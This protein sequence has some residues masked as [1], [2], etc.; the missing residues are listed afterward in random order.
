MLQTETSYYLRH[1]TTHT[2]NNKCTDTTN[3]ETLNPKP[4]NKDTLLLKQS[5]SSR[6]RTFGL[7]S[8]FALRSPTTPFRHNLGFGHLKKSLRVLGIFYRNPVGFGI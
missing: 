8:C 2:T 1:N 3:Y 4:C 7:E 6:T 5:S